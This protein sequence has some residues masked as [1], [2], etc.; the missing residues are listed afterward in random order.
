M[1]TMDELGKLEVFNGLDGPQLKS[2]SLIANKKTYAKGEV[3]YLSQYRAN[4]VFVIV[5]GYP[6]IDAF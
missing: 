4:R 1:V 5:K 2:L 3:V 6:Y